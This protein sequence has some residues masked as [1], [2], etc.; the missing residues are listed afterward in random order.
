MSLSHIK[1]SKTNTICIESY[2]IIYNYQIKLPLLIVCRAPWTK[3]TFKD[4][5]PIFKLVNLLRSLKKEW[6]L[7]VAMTVSKTWQN[8]WES[9]NVKVEKNMKLGV[10]ILQLPRQRRRNQETTLTAAEELILYRTTRLMER[11]SSFRADVQLLLIVN[12]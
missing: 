7:K 8:L 11:L 6:E 12:T 1:E 4:W 5:C 2:L 10:L 3:T 9:M